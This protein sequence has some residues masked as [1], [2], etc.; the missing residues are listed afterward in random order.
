MPEQYV[1][2][3][4]SRSQ[5]DPLAAGELRFLRFDRDSNLETAWMP[6]GIVSTRRE[7]SAP[8]SPL[9]VRRLLSGRTVFVRDR[10]DVVALRTALEV[11]IN[12]SVVSLDELAGTFLLDTDSFDL[13]GELAGANR[14]ERIAESVRRV[15]TIVADFDTLTLA[16]AASLGTAAGWPVAALLRDELELR[17]SQPILLRP[18]FRYGAHEISFLTSLERPEPLKRTGSK[19]AVD[20]GQIEEMLGDGGGFSRVMP[21]FEVR[22]AQQQMSTAVSHALSD[23][24]WLLVEAGTGTGKSMAYL[25]PAA[26]FAVERGERV[27]ISTNTKALQDQLMVKDIPDLHRALIADGRDDQLR[28]AVVKGRSNYLCLRRWFAH[29]RQPSVASPEAGLRAKVNLWLPL[30]KSGDRSELRLTG[31]EEHEFHRISAEGEVCN[32][33]RCVYQ[34]RNQCFLFRARRNAENAH[35]VVVNHALML[36]DSGGESS[37]LPGLRTADHR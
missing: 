36:S 5:T 17:E 22:R 37:I 9:A 28:A 10:A 12:D 27:V 26:R 8:T 7:D 30:T 35:L 11:Q 34:Q 33:S 29:E 20:A 31:E 4:I 24:G 2:V 32:A 13:D 1:A 25:L 16:R 18:E 3:S 6:F 19:D 15:M 14:E 23:D 21:G